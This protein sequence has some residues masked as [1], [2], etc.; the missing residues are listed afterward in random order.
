MF[1][2]SFALIHLIEYIYTG[3]VYHLLTPEN[4]QKLLTQLKSRDI[5]LCHLDSSTETFTTISP[6]KKSRKMKKSSDAISNIISSVTAINNK[7]PATEKNYTKRP[8]SQK[9]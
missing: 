7:E 9:S 4:Q 1:I 3:S 8:R 5:G 2:S 6:T